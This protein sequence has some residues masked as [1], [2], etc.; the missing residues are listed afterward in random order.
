M[1]SA[2]GCAILR[3]MTP[4]PTP[5]GRIAARVRAVL[6]YAGLSFE[7]AAR[8]SRGINAA[9]LRRIASASSPRGASLDELWA[10]ADACA[11]PRIWLT[12][13]WNDNVHIAVDEQQD[14]PSKLPKF[15]AGSLPE[16]L[17]IVELYL[18][19]LLAAEERRNVVE[20]GS[21]AGAASRRAG[22]PKPSATQRRRR[23]G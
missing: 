23:T 21:A 4:A 6:A 1:P 19:A 13:E 7:Q 5:E 9:T 17:E 2:H 18:K 8:R 16:R 10:I 12:G 11:V 15:G 20:M 14:P 22:K 3:S